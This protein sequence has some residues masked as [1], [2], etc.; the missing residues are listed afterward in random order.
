MLL[1]VE[2][3]QDGIGFRK[4]TDDGVENVLE[5]KT[6]REGDSRKDPKL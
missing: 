2:E 3:T 1:S 6:I 5:K 4:I